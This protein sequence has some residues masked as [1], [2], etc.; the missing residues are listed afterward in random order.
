MEKINIKKGVGMRILVLLAVIV[1]AG[2]EHVSSVRSFDKKISVTIE[3][4]KSPDGIYNKWFTCYP[5]DHTWSFGKILDNSL[6]HEF[7]FVDSAYLRLEIHYLPEGAKK[8]QAIEIIDT[9]KFF[10]DTTHILMGYE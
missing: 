9:V 1:F 3:V 7:E 6:V 2:C 4:E 8:G 10:N 5:L